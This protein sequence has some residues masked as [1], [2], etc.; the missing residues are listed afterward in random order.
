MNTE[1][2]DD[3]D[4][5]RLAIE[6]PDHVVF[7]RFPAETVLLNLQT[8]NYH[9]LNPTGGRMLEVLSEVGNIAAASTR[10]AEEY[11]QP[12]DEILQDLREF[13]SGLADRGLIEIH[14]EHD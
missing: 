4:L 8:G 9:S 5:D 14:A 6:V 11:E 7:R 2:R 12:L 10:L 3:G 1:Q 13:C